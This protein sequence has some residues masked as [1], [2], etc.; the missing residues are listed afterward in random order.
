MPLTALLGLWMMCTTLAPSASAAGATRS[1]CAVPAATAPGCMHT[2]AIAYASDSEGEEPEEELEEGEAE[3]AT[4]EVEAEEAETGTGNSPVLGSGS[5]GS[6]VVSHLE[7]TT[8]ATAA[9]AHRLPSVSAI[10]FSFAL[11]APARVQ[12]TIVRQTSSGG[13]T[14]WVTLPDSLTLSTARGRTAL[15]LKGHNRLSPGRYRLTVKP[16]NGHARSIYLNAPW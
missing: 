12:V 6:I 1:H 14:R 5:A 3:A 8:K 15:S 11:S 9:L 10:G 13:R 16:T 4:A 2:L 7:L